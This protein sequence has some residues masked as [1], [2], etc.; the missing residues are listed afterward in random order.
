MKKVIL[1]VFVTFGAMLTSFAA[2][3]GLGDAYVSTVVPSWSG[4]GMILVTTRYPSGCSRN[5]YE[6]L[7][8]HPGFD[9]NYKH[10]VIARAMNRKVYIVMDGC[11]SSGRGKLVSLYLK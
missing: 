10:A 6:M 4:G 1:A 11:T 9:M 8:T 5:E 2:P 3:K 7:T